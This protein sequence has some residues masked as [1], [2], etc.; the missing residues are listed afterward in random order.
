MLKDVIIANKSYV[1][2]NVAQD[3]SVDEIAIRVLR[4]D[5][6]DFLVP[7][8]LLSI[9]G[10]KEF[11]FELPDGIR[12]SYQP[13]KMHKKDFV[14]QMVSMLLPFKDC[15]DWLL[16]YHHICL[17]PQYIFIGKRNQKIHYLYLPAYE[18]AKT[19]K[20]IMEFFKNFVISVE[21]LD[22]KDFLLRIL[23]I[24]QKT[25]AN[26]LTLL[27]F[28]QKEK[29]AGD[30][31]PSVVHNKEIPE[32]KEAR[33][34]EGS[35]KIWGK[36]EEKKP[37]EAEQLRKD[38]P[39]AEQFGKSDLEGALL[40]SLYGS[41]KPEKKKEKK[42]EKKSGKE[43]KP[44]S[45]LFGGLFGGK[46]K[47]G[48][49]NETPQETGNGLTGDREVKEK[50]FSMQAPHMAEVFQERDQYRKEEE[51][52][53]MDEQPFETSSASVLRL[54]LEN[55]GKYAAPENIELNLEKGYV[56]VGRYDKYGAPCADFNFDHSITI[57]SRN[58]FRIEA[59]G[60]GYRIIDLDSD[61]GT[62][63]NGEELIPNMAYDLHTGDRIMLSR[64]TRLTYRVV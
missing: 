12:M 13:Q 8:K 51:L 30:P 22:D 62:L 48:L 49:E 29:N 10:S 46:K 31:V 32:K 35:G 23:R 37:V 59:W 33:I 14:Q 4:Q 9:D 52:T 42:K 17:D 6:P 11:R 2:F 19:D 60:D 20:E 45:G 50:S 21:L 3:E 26:L 39:S 40:S 55:A 57:I 53:E 15:G 63:L 56:T 1:I 16:D 5:C 18:Y 58:H 24:L 34:P 64:N 28:L 47:K 25:N 36:K 7:F 54:R 38:T 43:K 44:E 27:E 61:N 41:G